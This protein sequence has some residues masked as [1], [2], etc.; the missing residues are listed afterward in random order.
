MD[1]LLVCRAIQL[2]NQVCLR[3]NKVD[4]Y[5][6]GEKILAQ[7][8]EWLVGYRAAWLRD[9]KESQLELVADFVREISCM[10]V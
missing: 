8:E 3:I 7:F 10:N 6:D 4:G 9:N 2:M 1:L 5:L